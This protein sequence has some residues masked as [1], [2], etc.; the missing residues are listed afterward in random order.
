MFVQTKGE[1]TMVHQTS[2]AN[3]HR[4]SATPAAMPKPVQLLGALILGTVILFAA[5]FINTSAVHNAAHD[6]RHSQG[7]PCH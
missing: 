1:I 7:F 4:T 6:M 2:T 5:G 3:N